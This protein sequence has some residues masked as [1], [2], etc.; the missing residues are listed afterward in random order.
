MKKLF[1]IILIALFAGHVYAQGI[2]DPPNPP[3]LVNDFAGVLTPEQVD[4]LESKLEDFARSTTTQ[5]L[6]ITVSS[7]NGYDISDYSFQLGDKWG[8]GQ[9]GKNNG[10]III[11]KP[12]TD[13][14][15]GRAFIAVGYGLEGII[16]DA[17][18]NHIVNNE[19]IPYFKTGDI[20]GGLS[21]GSQ[22]IMSLA[23]KEFTAQEYDEKS[24]GDDMGGVFA[25][26]FVFIIFLIII[27]IATKNRGQNFTMGNAKSGLPFWM[28][29][30]MLG[31]SGGSNNKDWGDFTRGSGGFG[32][33]GGGGFGGFGGGSFGGGGAGGSW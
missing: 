3:R 24:S 28:L 17:T 20:Y 14:E 30:S 1:F 2:P 5:I 33:G 16:P 10:V 18:A 15:S 31:N 7:L 19:M 27:G 26:I 11:F 32:G 22:V 4:S 21:Q 29:L 12:K 25:G 9:K 8:V 6:I 13:Q 23:S